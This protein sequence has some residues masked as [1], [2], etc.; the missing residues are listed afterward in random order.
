MA[1]RGARAGLDVLARGAQ[2]VLDVDVR[3]RDERVDPR[4]RGVAYRLPGSLDVG[5][6]SAASPQMTGPSTCRAIGPHRVEVAG[7]GD[8]EARLDDVDAQPC[9]LLRD[10]ELLG[11]VEADPRRLLA[12]AQGGVE[13][14]DPLVVVMR[15][16]FFSFSAFVMSRLQA[17]ATRR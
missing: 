13:E 1:D 11:A 3:R 2:L 4:A 7:R 8:R 16:S 10:L 17:A 9:E 5:R 14:D 6:L 15:S 12:V